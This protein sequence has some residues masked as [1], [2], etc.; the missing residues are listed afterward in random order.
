MPDRMIRTRLWLRAFHQRFAKQYP[1][2][3]EKPDKELA[4]LLDAAESRKKADEPRE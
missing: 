2:K 4:R 3:D 1:V